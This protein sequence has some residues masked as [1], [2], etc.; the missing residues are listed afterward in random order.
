MF[1]AYIIVAVL[2]AAANAFAAIVDV[3][4]PQSVLDN[5]P[6]L[7]G[8]ISPAGYGFASITTYGVVREGWIGFSGRRC[9][10]VTVEGAICL[11]CRNSDLKPSHNSS[12][13]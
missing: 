2:T 12:R 3:C 13:N 5:T 10:K 11:L 7:A 8:D 9:Q 1:T 4:R 6:S